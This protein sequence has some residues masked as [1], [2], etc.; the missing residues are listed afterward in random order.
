MSVFGTTIVVINSYERAVEML[1]KKSTVYSD[2]PYVPMAMELLEMR[3]D[4]F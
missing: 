1:D 3:V 4:N 2:R